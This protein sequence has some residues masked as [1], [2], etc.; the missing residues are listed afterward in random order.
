MATSATPLPHYNYRPGSLIYID[1]VPHVH[2]TGPIPGRHVFADARTYEPYRYGLPDG[3]FELPTDAIVDELRIQGRMRVEPPLSDKVARR[4]AA[5]SHWDGTDIAAMDPEA[6][7]RQRVCEVL[8]E[9]GVKNGVKAIRMALDKQWTPALRKE[10]GSP[11]NPATVKRW[12]GERGT[13][14]DRKLDQMMDMT[15]RTPKAG[16]MHDVVQSIR[17]RHV[18]EYYSSR[19]TYSSHYDEAV[20]E[21]DRVNKGLHPEYAKPDVPHA[22][23]SY[24]AFRASCRKMDNR[25]TMASRHGKAWAKAVLGG[26]G[27]ALT[28]GRA[29]ETVIVDHTELRVNV[30]DAEREIV[31]GRPWATF[32]FD[33]HSRALLA[34]VI[35]FWP[36]SYWTVAA[37]IYR[38]TMPKRPPPKDA[39]RHPGL[40]RLCGRASRY[41][42]DN[43]A[44]FIGK[45]FEDAARS[46]GFAVRHCP[47]KAPTY[48]AIGER[49]IGTMERK[50]V[51][52]LGGKA[53][54]IEYSRLAEYDGEKLAVCTM[55]E[56]DAFV[57]K[58]AAEYNTEPHSGLGGRQPLLVFQKSARVHGIDMMDDPERFRIDIMDVKEDVRLE[59]TGLRLL[60]LRY[61]CA[62]NVPKLIDDNFPFEAA[63]PQHKKRTVHTRVKFNP[64]DISVVYVWSK[65]EKRYLPLKCSDPDYADGMPLWLHEQI[66]EAARKE[67]LAFNTAEE[68]AVARAE[69]V[70]AIRAI[71]AKSLKADRD[72][73]G[74]LAD[75]P[76][77]RQI[78]GNVVNLD[79]DFAQA[80]TT[81]DFIS[82]DVASLTSLDLEILA[83]R[84]TPGGD[85]R[86]DPEEALERRRAAR[87]HVGTRD[88]DAS[89]PARRSSRR[90]SD[91]S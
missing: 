10:F 20:A 72:M 9:L 80:V 63:R 55:A 12:R 15:G 24:D 38:S 25:H 41:L 88:S 39:L 36:P 32:V 70:A 17:W 46:A 7:K 18:L 3:T 53:L 29:L 28:A 5:Q 4:M 51:E 13:V 50:T 34:C 71:T 26:G 44:D 89:R 73:L 78:I 33:V 48:R 35:T 43:G 81:D 52:D 87:S 67:G 69:R 84:P 83:P 45:G 8:D 31:L 68:R 19:R 16:G 56:L 49:G 61:H 76:R 57:N 91:A 40:A 90:R 6:R 47:I 66:A 58:V 64:A 82:H 2:R 62:I 37:A 30:F 86:R 65:A 27:E 1:D 60:G 59:S 54:P 77:N 21:I 22:P 74:R 23:F 14:G 75:I 85:G 11:P 42:V 79:Y